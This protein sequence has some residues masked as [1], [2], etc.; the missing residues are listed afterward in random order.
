[1]AFGIKQGRS[2]FET[3]KEELEQLKGTPSPISP[4]A[5]KADGANPDQAKMAGGREQKQAAFQRA[6]EPAPGQPET[7]QQQQ[8][9]TPKQGPAEFQQLAQSATEKADRLQQLG[10]LNTRVQDLI[11]QYQ[12]KVTTTTTEEGSAPRMLARQVS[13]DQLATTFPDAAPEEL[14]TKAQALET[15]AQLEAPTQQNLIDLANSL[16]VGLEALGSGNLANLFTGGPEAFAGA[17]EGIVPTEVTIGEIG[18]DLDPADLDALSQDLGLTQEQL[19]GMRPEDFQQELEDL[20][21]SQLNRLDSLRA[22]LPTASPNRRAQ[23]LEEIKALDVTGTSA[24]EIETEQIQAEI[25]QDLRVQ[26]G[27]DE[28]S[29][30]ELLGDE[31]MSDKITLA[32]SNSADLERLRE[33]SPQLAEWVEANQAAI[34]ETAAQMGR[35]V[36]D[37]QNVNAEMDLERQS[38][39]GLGDILGVPKGLVTKEQLDQIRA[40][41]EQN[42]ALGFLRDHA[43]I[44][45]TFKENPELFNQIKDLSREQLDS[46]KEATDRLGTDAELAGILGVDTSTGLILDPAKAREVMQLANTWEQLNQAPGLKA[47]LKGL[48]PKAKEVLTA[49]STAGKPELII[50]GFNKLEKNPKLG[51]WIP[52][53]EHGIP[54][55]NALALEG[56]QI[57]AAWNYLTENDLVSDPNL[58]EYMKQGWVTPQNAAKLTQGALVDMSEQ[59]EE[60][61]VWTESPDIRTISNWFFG[62]QIREPKK[63]AQEFEKIFRVASYGETKQAKDF[64]KKMLGVFDRDGDG[65]IDI[66]RDF[67]PEVDVEDPKR[68]SLD[69]LPL[70]ELA[71]RVQGRLKKLAQHPGQV[72]G[73]RDETDYEGGHTYRSPL[74]TLKGLLSN[75]RELMRA[76]VAPKPSNPPP[77]AKGKAPKVLSKPSGRPPKPPSKP[78]PQYAR[79]IHG[80]PIIDHDNR[81]RPIKRIDPQATQQQEMMY[82]NRMAVYKNQKAKYDKKNAAYMKSK[83][84]RDKWNK[85]RKDYSDWQSRTRKEKNEYNKRKRQWDSLK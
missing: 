83:R 3:T 58:E 34:A 43:E 19:M 51:A 85:L 61:K 30:G 31:V 37:L 77:Q 8:R 23:I 79:D 46:L 42:Q 39:G 35:D 76:P 40:D 78:T 16:G 68:W 38:L 44:M 84:E 21:A 73:K 55:Y 65:R 64:N 6:Q 1:M 2:L 63:M 82:R 33:W 36:T 50:D 67:F 56:E 41:L 72:V 70:G 24:A 60:M 17:T 71:A 14:E 54:D 4:A 11:Q 74:E 13:R 5:A 27:E 20:E 7:L 26:I 69:E 28:F 57:D 10:S 47:K 45:N 59:L 12:T 81:G 80:R 75:P 22:E 48:G 53:D 9:I 66:W 49:I 15:Y 29:I 52:T 18:L 62:K 32:A 25:D